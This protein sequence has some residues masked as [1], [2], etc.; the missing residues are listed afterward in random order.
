MG[1]G[2]SRG[3]TR[4]QCLLQ[5]LFVT[6]NPDDQRLVNPLKIDSYQPITQATPIDSTETPSMTKKVG[7]RT[8]S[9]K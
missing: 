7:R 8:I 6:N 9:Q 2:V 5:L 1:N 4:P 3:A